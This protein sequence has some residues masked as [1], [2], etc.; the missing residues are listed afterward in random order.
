MRKPWVLDVTL[1][2]DPYALRASVNRIPR[3]RAGVER[4]RP[5]TA[6]CCRRRLRRRPSSTR[7]R[8]RRRAR[9]RTRGC[10]RARRWR[11]AAPR[12]PR[13]TARR[14]RRRRCR[15]RCGRCRTAPGGSATVWCPACVAAI[16]TCAVDV[17]S[18]N[19][20]V[21]TAI[22]YDAVVAK[23][24]PRLGD[25]LG[26]RCG[27]VQRARRAGA[28]EPVVAERV[29]VGRCGA[30][31]RRRGRCTAARPSSVNATSSGCVVDGRAGHR[32]GARCCGVA[33]RADPCP[34]ATASSCIADS[35]ANAGCV[36]P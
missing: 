3:A 35:T 4:A 6:G 33:V 16:C 19:S 30:A 31:P 18:P 5:A 1:R 13:R 26:R 9:R 14:S 7:R 23:R 28:D 24:G 36:M 34:S 2:G 15:S 32:R 27:L 12:C 29:P 25:V 21:P 17:P 10:G 20:T 8:R 22:S 11:P